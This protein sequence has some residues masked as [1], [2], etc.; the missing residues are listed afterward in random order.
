M[1]DKLCIYRRRKWIFAYASALFLA[2][3]G[4]AQGDL[5]IYG[6]RADY[7]PVPGA[8]LSNVRLAVRLDVVGSTAIMTFTNV[9]VAPEYSVSFK[10]ITIDTID[11]DTGL[12]VL[13]NA[14]ILTDTK[15]ISYSLD[16]Y[17]N[18][19]GYNAEITDGA[20]IVVLVANPPP[21]KDGMN[22]DEILQV[23]FDT[24]LPAG[25]D[26][27][28]YLGFFNGGNDTAEYTIAFHAISSDII[29]GESLGGAYV[30]EPI[31]ISLLLVGGVALL[32]KRR[33]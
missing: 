11:D 3:A 31:T 14:T 12:A 4:L 30:P 17:S 20:S 19:P 13:S 7:T 10:L 18:L 23:Q 33:S 15:S 27:Y 8:D 24:I 9:S 6:S 25:S 21:S 5:I 29:D 16:S 2:I 28:D 1:K 26:I 32:R 22:P